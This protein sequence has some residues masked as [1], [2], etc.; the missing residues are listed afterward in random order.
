MA[1]NI[2]G[3]PGADS[4]GEEKSKQAGKNGAKKSRERGEEP[5][6]LLFF[7]PF[8]SRRLDF[9]SPPLSEDGHE[10]VQ[11]QSQNDPNKKGEI[12]ILNK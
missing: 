7:A 2:L 9:P 4:E 8:F 11:G 3:D 5:C 12:I 6:S 1:R 10:I